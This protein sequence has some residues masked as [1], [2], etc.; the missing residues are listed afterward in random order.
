MFKVIHKDKNSK[1]RLGKLTTAHGQIDTPCFMPVGTQGTV[2]T[3]SPQELKDCGAQIILSNAY[4]LFL[5]PGREVIKKAG[6]LHNFISWSGPILT[7]SG[8]YQIFSLALLRQINDAGAEFQSHIDGLKHFL[9][10]EEVIRIQKDLGSD[11][12]MPLDECVHYPCSKDQATVAMRRTLDWARCSKE[13]QDN[14]ALLFGIVKGATYEDLRQECSEQLQAIGFD[15]YAI[16]GVSVG[17]PKNLRYNIVNFTLGFLP[18]DKPHYLMGVGIPEDIIGTVE[19][20]IDM[21]DCVVPT[22]YGRNGTA[23]TNDGKLVI[24]NAPYVVDFKPLDKKCSCY[25]CRN[26]SRAYLRHLFNTDEILGLRLVSL[27][28]VHFFL[29]LMRKIRE[30]IAQDRFIEFKKEFL[31]NIS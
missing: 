23:F 8:G 24:R 19:L 5:R 15:G 25:T 7:Y 22:R 2:K 6:G 10:P 9:T 20:G 11:I 16:G 18:Q 3:L 21:F 14:Q 4:H 29:E 28:N 13:A 30:A 26:F 31:T 1:A 12:I 17:E 27:H